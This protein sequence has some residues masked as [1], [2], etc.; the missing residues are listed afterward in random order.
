LVAGESLRRGRGVCADPQYEAAR[1][2]EGT[3]INGASFWAGERVPCWLPSGPG[4]TDQVYN[5]AES[6]NEH[7][8][9]LF[10]PA[11]ELELGSDD[12]H[13]A[14]M[15]AVGLICGGGG[16][17][18]VG[19]LFFYF[20][21]QNRGAAAAHAV[22]GRSPSPDSCSITGAHQWV[23]DWCSGCGATKNAFGAVHTRT[24]A[25]TEHRAPPQA[26]AVGRRNL[27]SRYVPRIPEFIPL[28][29]RR[30]VVVQGT[31]VT[32]AQAVA[33]VSATVVVKSSPVL[34]A[35]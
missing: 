9:K 6:Y 2:Q 18:L 33:T 10:S 7:C 8:I 3:R 24:G 4:T 35:V 28:P 31:S 17:M 14:L 15:F 1:P 27:A 25:S 22:I 11:A 30:P 29:G 32:G 20:W 26:P 23:G 21:K 34:S 5:C 13:G 16:S 19:L 12:A